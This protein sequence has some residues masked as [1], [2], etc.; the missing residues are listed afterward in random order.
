MWAKISWSSF[1]I[2]CR[3]ITLLERVDDKRMRG[4]LGP[5]EG[6]FPS[7]HVEIL[8]P[9]PDPAVEVKA[10]TP[11]PVRKS[12]PAPKAAQEQPKAASAA[13]ATPMAKVLHTFEASHPDE[14]TVV[15]GQEVG[16]VVRRNGTAATNFFIP[17]FLVAFS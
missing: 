14:L 11:E 8:V 16:W 7:S 15:A 13:D 10:A 4:A 12:A 2:I 3:Q 1:S 9:L 5:R 17:I 6:V